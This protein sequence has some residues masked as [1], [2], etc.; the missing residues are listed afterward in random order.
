MSLDAQVHAV[1]STGTQLAYVALARHGTIQP[2]DD[3]RG[4]MVCSGTAPRDSAAIE[5]TD[6][7]S[8]LRPVTTVRRSTIEISWNDP[9][10]ARR[11]SL[12]G[13]YLCASP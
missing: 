13:H 6:V 11:A 3:E 2:V 9:E 7:A 10:P 1:N 8:T 12:S 4:P 5:A